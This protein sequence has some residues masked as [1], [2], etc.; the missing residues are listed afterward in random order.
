MTGLEG[1]SAV[2]YRSGLYVFGGKDA[3]DNYSS[4]LW[5]VEVVSGRAIWGLVETT[6]EKPEPSAYHGAVLWRERFM[7][8]MGGVGSATPRGNLVYVLDLEDM[9]WRA[10]ESVGDI[11]QPRCH[12]TLTVAPAQDRLYLYGGYLVGTDGDS[13]FSNGSVDARHRPFFELH[14]LL[15]TGQELIWQRVMCKEDFPPTLWGHTASLYH[16]NLIVFGGVDVVDNKESC[17]AAVWHCE[18]QQWRWVEFNVHPQARALHTAVVSQGRIFIHGGFGMTNTCKF[19]DTW[20]FSMETGQ[21]LEVAAG[22]QLPTPRSG[23]AAVIAGDQMLVVG[24]VDANHTRL[25]DVHVLHIPTATWTCLPVSAPTA[26]PT[27]IALPL[28]DPHPST[29]PAASKADDLISRASAQADQYQQLMK[30]HFQPQ[31]AHDGFDPRR[32]SPQ[33]VYAEPTVSRIPLPYEDKAP[34]VHAP[35]PP[36]RN[37]FSLPLAVKDPALE[38]VVPFMDRPFT[39]DPRHVSPMRG[40]APPP[41]PPLRGPPEIELPFPDMTESFT[42]AIQTDPMPEVEAGHPV[43]LQEVSSLHVSPQKD[44]NEHSKLHG[45]AADIIQQQRLEIDMLREML[46]KE[47]NKAFPKAEETRYTAAIPHGPMLSITRDTITD[48]M[49]KINYNLT[50]TPV[51]NLPQRSGS[52]PPTGL[53]SREATKEVIERRLNPTDTTRLTHTAS[54]LLYP[55][56]LSTATTDALK[57]TVQRR[58]IGLSG[59]ATAAAPVNPTSRPDAVDIVHYDPLKLFHGSQTRDRSTG[60]PTGMLPSYHPSN[61]TPP[62][63]FAELMARQNPSPVPQ[64]VA[65]EPPPVNPQAAMPHPER[66]HKSPSLSKILKG[67]A[68]ML[69]ITHVQDRVEQPM[70]PAAVAP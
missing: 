21:W 31:E 70:Y 64:G 42:Q 10:K 61:Y 63:T 57:H 34:V 49:P 48:M 38:N 22:G 19:N 9:V 11:P 7:M 4:D 30:T 3:K 58:D 24:G 17:I 53:L 28:S 69:S 50:D 66:Q 29:Q 6:G 33:R 23:H 8:V 32:I 13:M 55:S 40:D 52:G 15:L 12:H 43:A 44:R 54:P 65:A 67:E 16:N 59:Q 39:G 45:E 37:R 36:V 2:W 46:E 56:L 20:T 27:P 25:N 68:S 51:L 14:E 5:R 26:P 35:A 18:K 41:P 1:H 47:R 62:A 60:P